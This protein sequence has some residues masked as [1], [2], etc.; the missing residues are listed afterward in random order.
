MLFAHQLLQYN[1]NPLILILLLP[2]FSSCQETTLF[3]PDKRYDTTQFNAVWKQ[4][5]SDPYKKLPLQKLSY[6]KLFTFSKNLILKDAKRTLREHSD[7][8]PY[9]NKLAH[10]N[11]ICFKGIWEIEKTNPYGGYFKKGSKGLIIV[12]ASSALSNT[13]RG[14]YRS[15]GFA[16]KIFPTLLADKT[17]K[18]H[19]ANFFLIDDLGGTKAS[20]YL[21]VSPLNEP[22]ISVTSEVL[23]FI[24]YAQKVARA[25]SSADKNS[26]I[27]QL[28]E[29]SYL[30]EDKN[31]KIITPR[32][33]KVVSATK[34]RVDAVDFRDEL[35]LQKNQKHKF[36]IYVS[37]TKVK[38]VIKWE[39]IGN[40]LLDISA[41]T[42]SCD[43]R[44]HFHHPKWRDD[45]IYVP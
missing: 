35:K 25:F 6:G 29:I 4:I 26:N 1:M 39:K 13:K 42:K 17:L 18:T 5:I 27:R 32:W 12:R 31:K 44:L 21:D 30:G 8:R 9:F 40:I 19:T 34:D 41:T 37:S 2:M 7:I 20:H 14:G 43:H 16:G 36:N 11:G 33:M 38:D 24:L 3:T 22:A 45:L 23:K 10:P 15:F 28:Y